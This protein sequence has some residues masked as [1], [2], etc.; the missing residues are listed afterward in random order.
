MVGEAFLAGEGALLWMPGFGFFFLFFFL[1]GGFFAAFDGD[2]EGFVEGVGAVGVF[3][4][5][6]LAAFP[7]DEVDCVGFWG[8]FVGDVDAYGCEAGD[9]DGG[10]SIVPG[11]GGGEVCEAGF[12]GEGFLPGLAGLLAFLL[13]VLALAGCFFFCLALAV[14]AGDLAGQ[15]GLG[16]GG[17]VG[18]GHG[19]LLWWG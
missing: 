12:E 15:D 14:G 18:G 9:A 13:F 17:L 3:E 1:Q 10:G 5:P 2:G 7:G 19:W 16:D 11:E 6:C 4:D 8:I